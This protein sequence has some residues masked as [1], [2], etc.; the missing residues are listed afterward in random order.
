MVEYRH[1]FIRI[2]DYD[3]PADAVPAFC[4]AYPSHGDWVEMFARAVGYLGTE[5]YRDPDHTGHF[6]TIERWRTEQDWHAFR[7]RFGADY[8]A[9]DARL[10]GLAATERSLFEG[11]SEP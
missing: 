11:V 9:L 7:A 4:A 3:V 5:L 10:D 8:G 2:W 6:L 1:V